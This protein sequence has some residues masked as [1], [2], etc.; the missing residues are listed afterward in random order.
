MINKAVL[1]RAF[2]L[3]LGRTL[4]LQK[5]SVCRGLIESIVSAIDKSHRRSSQLLW[6]YV[7]EGRDRQSVEPVLFECHDCSLLR[8]LELASRLQGLHS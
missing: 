6:V 4:A 3:W 7:V 8:W 2:H 5:S 1:A